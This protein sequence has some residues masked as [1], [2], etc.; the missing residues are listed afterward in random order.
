MP[1]TKTNFST[2]SLILLRDW[3]R[4]VVHD[5]FLNAHI[6]ISLGHISVAQDLGGT[7]EDIIFYEWPL[8]KDELN[9]YSWGT[10]CRSFVESASATAIMF[11]LRTLS[12]QD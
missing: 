10:Q 9:A 5:A 8:N 2:L 3:A 11:F 7:Y 12:H 1:G 4:F 6:N